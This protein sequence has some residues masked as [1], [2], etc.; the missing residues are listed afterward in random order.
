M[1][2][3]S[4]APVKA[5]QV[6]TGLVI[7]RGRSILLIQGF[8]R[9]TPGVFWRPPGGAAEF[10][11]YSHIAVVEAAGEQL[12]AA[13]ADV[14]YFATLES[15]YRQEGKKRHEVMLLFAGRLADARDYERAEWVVRDGTGDV[16]KGVWTDLDAPP[17]DIAFS[18]AGLRE[19]VLQHWGRVTEAGAG[20]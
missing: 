10:G 19:T 4:K 13:V 1:F 5:V 9:T 14:R 12:G 8:D 11:T 2:H 3:A 17:A 15:L 16:S 7:P 18:P 20:Q 6:S